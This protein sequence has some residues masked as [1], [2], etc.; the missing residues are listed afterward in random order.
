MLNTTLAGIDSNAKE[1]MIYEKLL[2]IEK[3]MK[4]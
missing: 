4:S 1:Y 3:S 2:V